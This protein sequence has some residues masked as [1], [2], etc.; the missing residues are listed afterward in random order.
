MN[1]DFSSRQKN[2]GRFE[3]QNESIEAEYL[4]FQRIDGKVFFDRNQPFSSELSDRA[5][6]DLPTIKA[7]KRNGSKKC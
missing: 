7:G 5:T 3:K 6:L 1:S 4:T 2:Q